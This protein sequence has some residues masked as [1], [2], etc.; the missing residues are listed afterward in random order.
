LGELSTI[1]GQRARFHRAGVK[2]L[3]VLEFPCLIQRRSHQ[4]AAWLRAWRPRQRSRPSQPRERSS[5]SQSMRASS[6]GLTVVRCW[7]VVT[8][9]CNHRW[10]AEKLIECQAV[11]SAA[12]FGLATPTTATIRALS[13]GAKRMVSSRV[14]HPPPS[15]WIEPDTWRGTLWNAARK[16]EPPEQFFSPASVA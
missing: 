10:R 13:N 7:K 1:I 3:D 9:H 4:G 16:R 14:A 5:T 8:A 12:Q 6:V 15:S 2:T 11:A